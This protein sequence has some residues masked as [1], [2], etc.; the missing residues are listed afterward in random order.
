MSESSAN[1]DDWAVS[2]LKREC[3]KRKLKECPKRGYVKKEVLLA[4]LVAD[5][6]SKKVKTPPT[7][8]PKRRPPPL[9]IPGQFLGA[10][11]EEPE[12]VI[13]KEPPS[14]YEGKTTLVIGI[15]TNDEVSLNR[16][17]ALFTGIRDHESLKWADLTVK[18]KVPPRTFSTILVYRPSVL[19]TSGGTLDPRKL[20]TVLSTLKD[21]GELRV[22]NYTDPD[23]QKLN[24]Y[25][26]GQGYGTASTQ[27]I[28]VRN[29][30]V[31]FNIFRKGM[32]TVHPK[33]P[34]APKG[35]DVEAHDGYAFDLDIEEAEEEEK[36]TTVRPPGKYTALK[37][38]ISVLKKT[39]VPDD[40]EPPVQTTG[41]TLEQFR[42]EL[43]REE[44]IEAFV[45]SAKA[46]FKHKAVFY[47]RKL[48]ETKKEFT[49]VQGKVRALQMK[50]VSQSVIK[51][52]YPMFDFYAG[53]M[54]ELEEL[55][56][57]VLGRMK[58]I[59]AKEIRKNLIDALEH[60]T[61][62]FASIVGRKD[63]KDGLASQLYAFSK[64]YKTF[65]NAF[66]NIC[67]MGPA[68]VGKTALAKVIGYVFSK[69][70]ILATDT[71]KICSRADMVGQYIGQ[72][73]PRT[74]GL[75]LETLEGVLFIDEAYQLTPNDPGRDFGPE[76]ITEVVN[77]LDK[78]IGM[79]VVIVAGYEDLMM[80]RFFPSN[81]GLSRRFPFR[82]LLE[83]YTRSELTD[84]L[85]QFIERR[86]EVK[87]EGELGNWLFSVISHLS[88]EFD[89]EGVFS[90]QAGDMLNLGASIVKSINSSYAVKWVPGDLEN[91]TPILLS[92]LNDYLLMKGLTMA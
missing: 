64:S 11:D 30:N 63:I 15:G 78:Y 51:E 87:V 82:L 57:T 91:N 83:R 73:A 59:T 42:A 67:L 26:V 50:G 72:T 31:V 2:R 9:L 21:T 58:E 10:D 29:H 76:A 90:N 20:S 71:V 48:V 19:F 38:N 12:V 17:R 25:L 77:F 81:E 60:P 89:D 46:L 86:A 85:V 68:G 5:D 62:G 55:I 34:S 16:S 84:I 7:P 47:K 74:R 70:G 44:F 13:V 54:V 4:I 1:Y 18:Q 36:A 52:M 39:Q 24:E 80:G 53:F 33:V 69:S 6:E 37:V 75:L 65:T 40:C 79:S 35:A 22:V 88:E 56:K 61:R 92:G 43:D 14:P 27:T 28:G 32:R 3:L 41:I 45:G 66:N 23:T 49:R 8:E